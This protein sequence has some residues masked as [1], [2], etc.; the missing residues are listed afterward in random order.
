LREQFNTQAAGEEITLAYATLEQDA[1]GE[2][3]LEE[4]S[5]TLPREE[6]DGLIT[7]LEEMKM[8]DVEGIRVGL[9]G[10]ITVTPPA[11]D[12]I[13]EELLVADI[14]EGQ[15]DSEEG[16][17]SSADLVKHYKEMKQ[18]LQDEVA[19][20]K[21]ELSNWPGNQTQTLTYTDIEKQSDGMYKKAEKSQVFT[22]EEVKILI[23]GLSQK[24]VAL[25]KD[26]QLQ[27][28]SLQGAKEESDET[29]E[30]LAQTTETQTKASEAISKKPK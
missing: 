25:T 30:T 11:L 17:E 24:L 18:L 12:E 3:R 8:D 1:E 7:R 27:L 19:G 2:Y 4:K 16:G 10:M 5:E 6:A 13:V 26:I 28:L 29:T 22:K 20:L 14:R 23:D 9:E 15:T 21:D